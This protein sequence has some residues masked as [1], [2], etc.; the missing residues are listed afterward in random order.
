MTSAVILLK[1]FLISLSSKVS[2]IQPY[3]QIDVLKQ[4][5][6]GWEP[7]MAESQWLGYL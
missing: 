7:G 2:Y 4:L 3:T 5:D 1:P 6:I